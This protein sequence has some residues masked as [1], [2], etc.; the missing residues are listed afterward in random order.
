MGKVDLEGVPANVDLDDS[1]RARDPE[2]SLAVEEGAGKKSVVPYI[3][4]VLQ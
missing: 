4:Y 3:G 1:Q 2:V